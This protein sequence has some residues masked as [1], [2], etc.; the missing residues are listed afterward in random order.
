M[1]SLRSS[2]FFL[3]VGGGLTSVACGDDDGGSDPAPSGGKGGGGG[4]AGSGGAKTG[5]AGGLAGGAKTGGAGGGTT[6]GG[7]PPT[8]G[9][10]PGGGNGGTTGG[11][12]ATGGTTESGAGGAA[13]GEAGQG[14]QAGGGG[15]AGEGGTGGDGGGGEGG[16]DEEVGGSGGEAGQVALSSQHLYVGC[17]DG[18]GTVQA[19]LFN[20]TALSPLGTTLTT[21]AISNATFNSDQDLLYVAHKVSN[22]ETKITTYTRNTTSGALTPLGTPADVP[23]VPPSEGGAGG[24]GGAPA[25]VTEP[26]PQTLTLDNNGDFLAVP[27]Y[28][29]NNVYVYEVL[30]NGSVGEIV[31]DDSDGEKAHH[32]IFSNNNNFMLVPYLGSDKITVYAFDDATGDITVDSDETMPE[33][34]SGPRHI[35]LHPNGTWLYAIHETAGGASSDA[36]LLDFFTFNQGNG[37]ITHQDSYEVPLPD[38]YTGLKNGSEIALSPSGEFVYVS[39]RLDNAAEGSIVVFEVNTGG[40]LSFV[41]QVRTHGVTPRQFSISSDGRLL[42]VG[43]QNSD[44]VAL[45]S[46]AASNGELTFLD[47]RDVCDSPRFARFADIAN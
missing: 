33:D 7:A 47:D 17:A 11:S 22:G 3:F 12:I 15:A 10:N 14:G 44:T 26:G 4:I 16:T 41:Q 43:N 23:I 25:G 8:G 9:N 1:L 34:D 18:S 35:A 32:A 46:I 29:S 21:G 38:G 37:D 28:N 5:G 6:T 45:F 20:G 24:E 36:G 2:L 40:T 30:G 13:A 19:Y 27:N 31:S 42:V 39:M